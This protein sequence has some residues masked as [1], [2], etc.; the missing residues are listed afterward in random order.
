MKKELDLIDG[1][2][3]SNIFEIAIPASTAFI[4]NTLFN[5]TDTL[6]TGRIGT[7][8]LA[9]LS[10]SFPLF[11]M[12]ISLGAG[13]S[14]GVTALISNTIGKKDVEKGVEYGNNALSLAILVSLIATLVGIFVLK[15]LFLFMKATPSSLK[16]GMDYMLVIYFGLITFVLNYVFNSI[17]LAQG[18][19]KIFRNAIIIGFILNIFLDY[20]FLEVFNLGTAGVAY[21]TILI[22]FLGNFYL[23]YH[24]LNSKLMKS[25][26]KV[27]HELGVY[28]EILKQ[29]IPATMGMMTIVI[30]SFVINYFVSKVGRTDGIAAYGIALRI[31]QLVLLPTIGLNSA[32]LSIAGQNFGARRYENITHVYRKSLKIAMIFLIFAMFILFFLSPLAINIFSKNPKV[33][34][35][36]TGYFKVEAFVVFTYAIQ[37]IS[38]AVLQA[39]KKPRYAIY[40]GLYRQLLLPIILFP[41]LIQVWGIMGIWYGIFIVNWSAVF[42]TVSITRK[43][44]VTIL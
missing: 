39:M 13:L 21:A 28:K 17:L 11:F 1:N 3:Y 32:V 25:R 22:Q 31:E 9:G 20:F 18:N 33:I 5:I 27:L 16:Y 7:D 40:V 26:F 29:S 24:A 15:P 34:S 38:I 37:T 43:T 23:G 14:T 4:F 44:L 35:Y 12:T 41:I 8:A 42:L 10:L 19:T 6:F 2:M 30:G 36:G